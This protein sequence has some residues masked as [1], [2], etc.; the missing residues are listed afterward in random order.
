MPHSR[1]IFHISGKDVS[2]GTCFVIL[3]LVA[4]TGKVVVSDYE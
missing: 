4:E 2:S 1:F 3:E